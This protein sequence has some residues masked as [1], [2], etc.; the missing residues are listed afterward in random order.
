[1]LPHHNQDEKAFIVDVIQRI[2]FGLRHGCDRKSIFDLLLREGFSE[3]D[4]YLCYSAAVM[5]EKDNV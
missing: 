2:R 4:V 1:M 5:M 3:G